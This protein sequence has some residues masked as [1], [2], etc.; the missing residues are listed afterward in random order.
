ME[1]VF[2]PVTSSARGIAILTISCSSCNGNIESAGHIFFEC[3]LVKEVWSLVRKWCD[4]PFLSL[5]SYDVWKNWICSWHAPK[6]KSRRLYVIFAASFLWMWRYRNNIT[7]CAQS[8]RKSDLFD[9]IRSS[10][11]S[12][13]SYRGRMAIGEL[14]GELVG[15]LAGELIGELAGEQVWELVVGEL[16]PGLVFLF[17][18]LASLFLICFIS[19]RLVWVSIKITPE[20]KPVARPP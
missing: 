10:S 18:S 8:M 12:W 16:V 14:A 20:L 13:L 7:F 15:H 6:E 17:G 11:Y 4:I 5:A 1:N 9:N 2:G 3:D 19:S